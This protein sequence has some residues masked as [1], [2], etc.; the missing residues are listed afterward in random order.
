MN[1]SCS[2][3]NVL[4]LV[5]FFHGVHRDRVAFGASLKWAFRGL[6][7]WALFFHPLE[8]AVCTTFPQ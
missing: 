8:V 3:G 6:L 7:F 1:C 2:R 4:V 5:P